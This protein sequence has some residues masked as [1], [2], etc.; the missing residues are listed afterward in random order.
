MTR[1]RRLALAAVGLVA[2]AAGSTILL[3][4]RDSPGLAA[5]PPL[6]ALSLAALP[7][8]E[9]LER[10]QTDISRRAGGDWRRL[11]EAQR[12]LLV[13]GSLEAAICRP[14][15][16]LAMILVERAGAPPGN[17]TL[18]ELAEA[19]HWLG[20]HEAVVAIDGI[21]EAERAASDLLAAWES[22]DASDP[23]AGPPPRNPF[24][25]CAAGC[26][27]AVSGSPRS[28][29]AWIRSHAEEVLAR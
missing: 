19:Y 1:R 15:D 5:L 17:P 8:G 13:L 10:V 12:H 20:L 26:R 3:S 9:L 16:L 11:P 29:S 2:L 25:A 23:Q 21:R 24:T 7:D 14:D 4:G 22:R 28:R 6:D 18:G 27:R